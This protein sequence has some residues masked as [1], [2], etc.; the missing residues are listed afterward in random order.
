MVRWVSFRV[1]IFGVDWAFWSAYPAQNNS[2]NAHGG[3]APISI[4][5]LVRNARMT[6]VYLSNVLVL[7]FSFSV[8]PFAWLRERG[9]VVR[10]GPLCS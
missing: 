10:L 1:C 3:M 8:F 7:G 6:A 2:K 4:A 9:A 5:V